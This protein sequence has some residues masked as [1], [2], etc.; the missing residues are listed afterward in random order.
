MVWADSHRISRAPWYLGDK[1]LRASDYSLTRLS[2]STVARSRAFNLVNCA[3]Q[4][5]HLLD[6]YS[7]FPHIATNGFLHNMSFLLLPFRSPL[8]RESLRFLFLTLLR[9]FSSRR[10]LPYPM[11]SDKDA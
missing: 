4:Q 7:R 5:S 10:Y 1:L 3:T 11:Y 2:L 6:T 9:C 8:L